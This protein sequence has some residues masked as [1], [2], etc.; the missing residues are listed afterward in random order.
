MSALGQKRTFAP[1]KVVSALPPKVDITGLFDHLVGG[2]QQTK[3][4]GEA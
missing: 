1:Q 2:V 4:H 3:W